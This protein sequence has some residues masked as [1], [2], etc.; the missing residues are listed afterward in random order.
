MQIEDQVTG[1]AATYL[2]T[3]QLKAGGFAVTFK[4]RVEAVHTP[5]KCLVP[6]GLRPGM[7]VV[8]KIPKTD[9]DF[10][11]AENDQ[12]IDRTNKQL[13][14]AF[15]ALCRLSRLTCVARIL[16]HGATQVTLPAGHEPVIATF[17][18]EEFVQGDT[19]LDWRYHSE[20]PRAEGA[21]FS[22]LPSATEFYEIA[23][24][25]AKN[26]RQ[27][28]RCQVLH[29]DIWYTNV[30]RRESDKLP[31]YIDFGSS[32]FRNEFFRHRWDSTPQGHPFVAPEVRDQQAHGRRS[33]IYGLGGLLY[34]LATGEELPPDANPDNDAMRGLIGDRLY[35]LNRTLFGQSYAL[36]TL[37][38][39]CMRF[40]KEERI[41]TADALLQ[42]IRVLSLRL[43]ESLSSRPLS[44]TITEVAAGAAVLE[45]EGDHFFCGLVHAAADELTMQ[46]GDMRGG[47]FELSGGHER[48]TSNLCMAL[49]LLEKGDSFLTFSVPA[50][51][52]RANLGI[53]GR[54]LVLERMLVQKG[55]DV[56]HIFLMCEED[57][58]GEE[59]SGTDRILRVRRPAK[60]EATG[61]LKYS[62]PEVYFR[63]V[64]QE[65]RNRNLEEGWHRGFI[66]KETR[67][68]GME[69]VYG[70]G[71]T[72]RTVR[73]VNEVHPLKQVQ[74]KL[75]EE[76]AQASPIDMWFD[77]PQDTAAG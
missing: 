49:S 15:R 46:I 55:V 70:E 14:T 39:R 35:A 38:A 18:A 63:I 17:L 7:H 21:F 53:D 56:R 36:P 68:T 47:V 32:V 74:K 9:A 4:A 16:D 5:A 43:A 50:L 26:L 24:R 8:I 27:I 69:F 1:N 13:R 34:C 59:D 75:K 23:T 37:I 67:V 45:S 61:Q 28:H 42:E 65:E 3:N 20:D 58:G 10:S 19:L 40:R 2:I 30:M 22:P 66:I 48:I 76:I 51:W 71:E 57:R 29:G 12:Y 62:C 6:N 31:V 64:S 72:L 44:D 54:V 11:D 25:L 77:A 41:A 52:S 60:D 33:D 73:L